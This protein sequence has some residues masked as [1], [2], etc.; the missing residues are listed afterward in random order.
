[1][2]LL[3]CAMVFAA[4]SSATFA[5][6]PPKIEIFGGFSYLNYEAVS[7]DFWGGSVTESCSGESNS[8]SGTSSSCAVIS[9][10][11]TDINFTPRMGLY[12]WNGSV[13]AYLTP[14]FGVTT[15]FSGNYSNAT[16]S[17]TATQTITDSPCTSNC[18]QTNVYQYAVS[19][20]RIHTFLFGPQFTFPAGKVRL[21]SRF[22]AGGMNRNA[23]LTGTFTTESSSGESSGPFYFP[24]NSSE[25]GNSFA[26]AFG[27]G[28]DYPIRKKMAWRTGMDYLTSTG[29]AQNHLRAYSGIVWQ[30]GK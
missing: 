29:T 21:Y 22:L 9:G 24:Y 6:S 20:P 4:L 25:V 11:F 3:V 19:D 18:T 2:R 30:L 26:M 27:G 7:V 13:T 8:N 23:T 15:D 12:G 5:Q 28:V 10:S 14:W 1:M 16:S 17:K